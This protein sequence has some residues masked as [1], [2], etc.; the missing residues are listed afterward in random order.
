MPGTLVRVG[1]VLLSTD[2]AYFGHLTG[3][4]HPECPER[5]R[6]VLDGIRD[7]GAADAIVEVQ[8]RAATGEE[9][10]R[11]HAPRYLEA[12]EQFCAAGGGALD[13]D[14]R[15][16]AGSWSAALLAAGAGPDAVE[17]LDRGEADA[18]FLAVRPPGHHATPRRA[19]GFCL[20][21]NVAV[22]AASLAA[23]GERVLIVDWDAHHGNGTQDAFYADPRV[24]YV[25]LHEYPQYPG[26]GALRETGEG[27]GAGATVNFP[28]P[29]GTSGDSYRAAVDEVILPLAE[30]FQPTWVIASAGF[31][32]HRADPITD[33][34]LSAGDYTDLTA[35]VLGLAPPGHRLVFL[36]GG[37]DLEALAA[38]AG[39]CVAM[40][41][42][43]AQYPEQVTSGADG[44]RAVV[45]AVRRLHLDGR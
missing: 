38:S 23:R 15:A 12:V 5:L 37:Y 30:R 9:L 10:E 45:E 2:P 39:A 28:F 33:L 7:S 32:A 18:A 29:S 4:H 42:G 25:S 21:N 36:E 13:P 24:V 35:R 27:A 19:M 41:A 8:P 11:V 44:G 6:A 20:I 40:M 22:C 3:P 34:G 43:E 14:T 26:T 17:R 16:S 1:A 31:D